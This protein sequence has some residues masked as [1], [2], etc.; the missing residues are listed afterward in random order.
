MKLRVS[1]SPT[2]FEVE[3]LS[4]DGSEVRARIDGEEIVAD[5]DAAATGAIIRL[6]GRSSRFFAARQRD[7]IIVALGPAQFEFVPMEATARRRSSTSVAQTIVAPM[8]GKVLK[9]LVEEQ[10]QVEAGTPLLVLEAM[11]METTLSAEAPAIV[12][13]I[14]ATPDAMVDHGAVLIELGPVP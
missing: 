3:I 1:G 13:K 10:Q 4:R 14:H 2:I 7:G 9:V 11:K 6:T 5:V 12:A 8:P